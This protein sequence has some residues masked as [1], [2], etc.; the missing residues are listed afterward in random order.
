MNDKEMMKYITARP[1]YSDTRFYVVQSMDVIIRQVDTKGTTH[2]PS[3]SPLFRRLKQ[4]KIKSNINLPS[5][6]KTH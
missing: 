2:T 4:S 5:N 3:L 6:G 1:L